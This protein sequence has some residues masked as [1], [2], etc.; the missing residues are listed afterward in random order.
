MN[1]SFF[2]SYFIFP[3]FPSFLVCD[4]SGLAGGN[5]AINVGFGAAWSRLPCIQPNL[6]NLNDG[7]RHGHSGVV[8][9][10]TLRLVTHES[11]FLFKC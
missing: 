4:S 7:Y 6:K 3:S 10:S 9:S 8:V 2:L 5:V 11:W 1:L